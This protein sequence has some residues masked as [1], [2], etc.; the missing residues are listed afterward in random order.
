MFKKLLVC[1]ILVL[2]AS[3]LYAGVEPFYKGEWGMSPQDI[4][5]LYDAAPVEETRESGGPTPR[6]IV[7]DAD[8]WGSPVRVAYLFDGDDRLAGVC[9]LDYRMEDMSSHVL[10][11]FMDEMNETMTEALT[12]PVEYASSLTD[13]GDKHFYENAWLGADMYVNLYIDIKPGETLANYHCV[14]QF[15][16]RDTAAE[17]AFAR[18]KAAAQPAGN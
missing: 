5:K 1:M 3:P 2:A 13:T 11:E 18:V 17:E 12:P 8:L 15:F 9:V 7:Y 4:Q 6:E 14:F 10:W 16:P